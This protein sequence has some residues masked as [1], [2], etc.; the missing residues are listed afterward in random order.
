MTDA[1]AAAN[2]TAARVSDQVEALRGARVLCLGDV[3]LDRYVTGEVS[4]VSPE[5][6]IPVCRVTGERA[7]LGGAGNVARNLAALGATTVF[8]TV[9]GDDAAGAEVAGLVAELDAE[10]SVL[11][12]PGRRT[13]VKTRYIADGQQLLRADRETEAAIAAAAED[14]I[15]ARFDAAI[16]GVGAVVLSDYGK[17]VLTPGLIGRAIEA[18]RRAGKPVVVDPK[19]PDYRV[20]RGAAILTPNRRE[21]AQASQM[22]DGTDAEIAAAA[23]HIVTRC[24]VVAVL[25]TRGGDGMT[26]VSSTEVSHLAAE[27]REVFDVSG[28]GDTVV[29]A[30][31]AALAAGLE[32]GDAARLAN[33][34]AGIVVAKAG[35]AVAGSDEIVDAMRAGELLS[36]ERKSVGLPA[37][38]DHLATWRARGLA[39]GFTNGCFDLIHPGHVS[40]LAQAR[41]AC[42]RLVVGL[43]SDA[44]AR[45]LKGDGRPVQGAAARAAV[46]GS[47]ASVDLVVIFD[48]DTPVALIEAIRPDVLVKGA[49]YS[50]DQVVGGDIVRG[51]G[52]RVMLADLEPGHSTTATIA[53]IGK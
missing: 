44:S 28:A 31:A 19:G 25:V 10:A 50:L 18:A 48:D 6:P 11:T 42:D 36:G 27:A 4:R 17:G 14:E 3:M 40:L 29:A 15:M 39:V 8:I 12:A 24:E 47:L 45:R 16:A 7:M 37:A 21:L 9:I 38:L 53:R 26:L 34:A 30:V 51:Y 46:L 41:A 2:A 32:A 52:G 1:A 35:T 22:A 33:V 20:Y 43:N 23:R 13:T 49:D 5:A